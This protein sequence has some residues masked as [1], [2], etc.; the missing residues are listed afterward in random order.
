MASDI[1]RVA[2]G[3]QRRLAE[4]KDLETVYFNEMLQARRGHSMRRTLASKYYDTWKAR[5]R[6]EK[7]LAHLR[8]PQ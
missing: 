3:R 2:E 4:L 8:S 7:V 6:L 1:E 5:K